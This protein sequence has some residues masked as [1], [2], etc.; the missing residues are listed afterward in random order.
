VVLLATAAAVH[1]RA[2]LGRTAAPQWASTP[3]MTRAAWVAMVIGVGLT[4]FTAPTMSTWALFRVPSFAVWNGLGALG[5]MWAVP[6][7][8]CLK[9]EPPKLR[10]AGGAALAAAGAA[11]L[12]FVR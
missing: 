9:Q 12:G 5:P 10:T 4:T 8:W 7:A 6:L 1:L 3:H 2:A 11:L